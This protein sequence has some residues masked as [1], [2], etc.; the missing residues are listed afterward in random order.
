LPNVF[1]LGDKHYTDLPAYLASFDICTIPYN[2]TRQHS[3]DPIK[4]YEYIAMGKP[5]VTTNIGNVGAFSDFPQVHIAHTTDEFIAGIQ[6]E[7]AFLQKDQARTMGKLPEENYWAFKVDQIVQKLDSL[8][9]AS[10]LT[11]VGSSLDR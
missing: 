5:V 3:V 9:E 7:V 8:A 4:F 11:G 1:Y 2:Q 6:H 10:M